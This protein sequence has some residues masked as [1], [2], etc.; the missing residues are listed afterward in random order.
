MSL[1]PGSPAS[2]IYNCFSI[3]PPAITVSCHS[4]Y[5]LH[6]ELIPLPDSEPPR[7]WNGSYLSQVPQHLAQ[8]II[9]RQRGNAYGNEWIHLH[10]LNLNLSSLQGWACFCP[11]PLPRDLFT[12]SFTVFTLVGA[13]AYPLIGLWRE[14]GRGKG[15]FAALADF[16]L[17]NF[18]LR[19]A[20]CKLESCR[21]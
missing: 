1:P 16:I 8:T 18:C 5:W 20:F 15:K 9:E 10:L 12:P 21:P 3:P 19:S 2:Q 6:I 4:H 11:Y 7:S 14:Q 17:L 13:L